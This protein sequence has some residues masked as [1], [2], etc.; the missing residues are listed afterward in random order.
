MGEE[1]T[2]YRLLLKAL[3]YKQCESAF[4]HLSERVSWRR[5]R[6]IVRRSSRKNRSKAVE[7]TLLGAAGFIPPRIPSLRKGETKRFWR[8]ISAMYKKV[9]A[10]IKPLAP[11][12]IWKE[13]RG[14]PANAPWRRIAAVSPLLARGAE[15]GFRT[16]LTPPG[17]HLTVRA[18][19]KWFSSLIRWPATHYFETHLCLRGKKLKKPVA[20]IGRQRK[21][22]II[23]NVLLPYLY[24]TGDVDRARALFRRLPAVEPHAPAKLMRSRLLASGKSPASLPI[25]LQQG[26]LHLYKTGCHGKEHT[27]RNNCTVYTSLRRF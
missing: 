7:A 6:V 26:L 1:Q 27:C 16:L 5:I 2:V 19:E 24:F 12:I 23:T 21:L 15:K 18:L 17:N 25:A 13:G 8:S 22:R 14:R 10:G 20:L 11:E 9:S 3:G 4:M